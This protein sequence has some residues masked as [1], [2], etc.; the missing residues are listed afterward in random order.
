MGYRQGYNS[1]LDES[2]GAKHGRKSQNYR[3]RRHESEAMQKT[4][5]YGGDAS[6][7]KMPFKNKDISYLK[8][9]KRR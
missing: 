9:R 1:R 6:M 3:D 5:K 2:L 7:D 4:H 8:T